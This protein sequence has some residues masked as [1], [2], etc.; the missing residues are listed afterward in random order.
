[1]DQNNDPF[2]NAAMPQV[3]LNPIAKD[4]KNFAIASLIL[5][6][7]SILTICCCCINL[8][9]AI[10]AIVFAV[11]AKKRD[12]KMP[13]MALIGMILAIVAIVLTL[14]LFG[15]LFAAAS[16]NGDVPQT[17]DQAFM[18]TYGMSFREYVEQARNG[19]VPTPIQ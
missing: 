4:G 5:G 15:F 10:L 9:P 13:T 12:G 19:T 3:E 7:V 14:I 18:E 2:S 17:L 6:I 11:I 8:I 16:G 1:M